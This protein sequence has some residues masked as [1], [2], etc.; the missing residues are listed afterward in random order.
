MTMNL[1]DLPVSEQRPKLDA[2]AQIVMIGIQV[3]SVRALVLISL[4]LNTGV[5]AW[6]IWEGTWIRLVGA[7]AFA[8]TSWCTVNLK[9]PKGNEP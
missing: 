8:V 3:L 9:P 5:F 4:L 6:A 1:N 2:A 7:A